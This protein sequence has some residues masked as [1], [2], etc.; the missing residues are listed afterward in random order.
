MSLQVKIYFHNS[1]VAKDSCIIKWWNWKGQYWWIFTYE[2]YILFSCEG[3]K[4]RM[5]L[6]HTFRWWCS[7][8]KQVLSTQILKLTNSISDDTFPRQF[9]K[10]VPDSA[11]F[12]SAKSRDFDEPSPES[13]T[14]N[15]QDPSVGYVP[16]KRC[17]AAT[18]TELLTPN[19]F[20]TRIGTQR[21]QMIHTLND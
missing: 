14:A 12:R 9:W 21:C 2:I 6:R 4:L 11:L 7:F 16:Q 15:S 13:S 5:C 18:C 20:K 19:F 17:H 8:H 1:W 3:F 10:S